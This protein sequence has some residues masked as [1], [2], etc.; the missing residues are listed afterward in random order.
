MNHMIV[1]H[2]LMTDVRGRWR[3]L[4]GLPADQ[5]VPAVRRSF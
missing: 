3:I 4:D 2:I 5:L 1:A